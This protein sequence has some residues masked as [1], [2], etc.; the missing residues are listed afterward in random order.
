MM[1]FESV[2]VMT[3]LCRRTDDDMLA[4]GFAHRMRESYCGPSPGARGLYH[5]SPDQIADDEVQGTWCI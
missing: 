1:M 3:E 2:E 5:R 4:R